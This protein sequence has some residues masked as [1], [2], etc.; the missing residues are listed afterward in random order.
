L[1]VAIMPR[2]LLAMTHIQPG[3]PLSRRKIRKSRKLCSPSQSESLTNG[4]PTRFPAY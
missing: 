3:G 2:R 1:T 4:M